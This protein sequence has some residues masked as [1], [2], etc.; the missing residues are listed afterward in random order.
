MLFR[1][2]F[3]GRGWGAR[4]LGEKGLDDVFSVAGAVLTYKFQDG[5]CVCVCLC[6]CVCVCACVCACMCELSLEASQKA[7]PHKCLP[8]CRSPEVC[9]DRT[10]GSTQ[11]VSLTTA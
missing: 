11:I 5:L 10:G 1:G 2:G 7:S 3:G 4:E 8:W 9:P 6:M